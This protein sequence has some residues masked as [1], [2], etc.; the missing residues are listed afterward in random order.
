MDKKVIIII[1]GVPVLLAAPEIYHILQKSYRIR[2]RNTHLWE[3]RSFPLQ[4]ESTR[5]KKKHARGNTIC[6]S[7]AEKKHNLY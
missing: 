7:E 6:E 4:A 5:D 2:P 3:G 1:C